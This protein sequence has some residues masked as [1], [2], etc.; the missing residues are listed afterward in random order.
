MPIDIILCLSRQLF[1]NDIC[2]CA[3]AYILRIFS[4][5][6]IVFRRESVFIL[7]C[8]P[9]LLGN[10]HRFYALSIM[11]WRY[12]NQNQVGSRICIRSQQRNQLIFLLIIII[13]F[14]EIVTCYPMSVE[15]RGGPRGR[16]FSEKSLQNILMTFFRKTL[17]HPPNILMTIIIR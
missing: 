10:D 8:I 17:I 15:R 14:L 16:H 2:A 9:S 7:T 1:T 11:Y 13:S 3:C 12:R 6:A 4:D 5:F